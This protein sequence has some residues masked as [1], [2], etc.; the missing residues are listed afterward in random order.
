MYRALCIPLWLTTLV[1]C[2]DSQ[3]I[4]APLP[5]W[6]VAVDVRDSVTDASVASQARGAVFL[7]GTLE[8]SL[9]PERLPHLSSDTLLVGGMTEGLV[10][11]RVEHAG[12][13]GWT[14]TGVQTRLSAGQC[15]DWETQELVARLQTAP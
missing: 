3:V 9:R 5:A 13:L 12:Y 15:P 4:C 11:V 7:A 1:G 10:E 14:A 2:S 6:A 8:D